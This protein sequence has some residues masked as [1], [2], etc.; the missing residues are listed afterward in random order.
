MMHDVDHTNEGGIMFALVIPKSQKV[1][2][3]NT[4]CVLVVPLHRTD[5]L[6]R[7]ASVLVVPLR[8]KDLLYRFAFIL[9]MTKSQKVPTRKTYLTVF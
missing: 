8:R 4:Y 7:F 6:H 5:L 2:T 1:P 3:R 9:I